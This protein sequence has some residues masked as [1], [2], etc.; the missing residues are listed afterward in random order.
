MPSEPSRTHIPLGLPSGL[1]HSAVGSLARRRRLARRNG[2]RHGVGDRD[3][4]AGAPVFCLDVRAV[5]HPDPHGPSKLRPFETLAL[6]KRG[7]F[8]FKNNDA[9]RTA[10]GAM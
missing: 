1:S 8:A 9:P 5:H 7:S 2:G 10:R 6:E 4:R 3:G